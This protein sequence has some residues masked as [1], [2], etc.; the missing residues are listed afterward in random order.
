MPQLQLKW[1]NLALSLRIKISSGATY[2]I[3]LASCLLYAIL[4]QWIKPMA[5]N[6]LGGL[7]AIWAISSTYLAQQ[8]GSNKLDAQVAEANAGANLNAIKAAAAGIPAAETPG[9]PEEKKT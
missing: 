3:A 1:H 4:S 9:P 6:F 5:D 8:H 2:I 7:A